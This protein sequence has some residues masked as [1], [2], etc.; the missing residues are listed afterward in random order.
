MKRIALY[1]LGGLAACSASALIF[2]CIEEHVRPVSDGGA[3]SSVECDSGGPGGFPPANCDPSDNSCPGAGTCAM[4]PQACGDPATCR[5]LA[6]NKGK[7]TY[8][9][10]LR[11]LL[12][13]APPSLAGNNIGFGVLQA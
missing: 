13:T 3:S 12:I 11:R 6:D 10:R 9:L 2:A 1:F 8:D 4:D 5:P 7:P